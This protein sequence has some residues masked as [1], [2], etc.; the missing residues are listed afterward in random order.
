MNC[1]LLPA[2]IEFTFTLNTSLGPAVTNVTLPPD[3]RVTLLRELL[4]LEIV[5]A[6][7]LR[8]A[9]PGVQVALFHTWVM[10]GHTV[11]GV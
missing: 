7:P 6:P 10:F 9:L 4:A 1:V 5:T 3:P 8:F 11:P 2:E